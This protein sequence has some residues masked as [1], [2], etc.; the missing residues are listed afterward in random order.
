MFFHFEMA[1]GVPFQRRPTQSDISR[2][3]CNAGERREIPKALREKER[4]KKR[5]TERNVKY[6][7]LESE[8]HWTSQQQ[9]WMLTNHE[10]IYC[11]VES[12][13]IMSR[14]KKITR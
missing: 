2:K 11:T 10:D 14:I 5:D 7:G 9:Y 4:G 1:H 13:L 8:R 3:F 6:E 12:Q